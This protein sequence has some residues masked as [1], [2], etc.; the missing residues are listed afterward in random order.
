[1]ASPTLNVNQFAQAAVQGDVDLGIMQTGVLSGRISPNQASALSAG[2]PVNLDS[3]VTTG[4]LPMFVAAASSAVALGYLKR[5]LRQS[6][7]A[8]GDDCEVV[9]T[10]APVIYLTAKSTVA[11]GAYVESGSDPL[12]VQTLASG[13]PRGIA[14]EPATDGTLVRV[15]L[16]QAST[17][18]A[19]S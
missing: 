6:S 4:K 7:F 17:V 14:L 19:A 16:L 15:L 12:T 2:T 1:M 5:T 10:P 3:A 13:K 9:L 11:M 18:V 8:T